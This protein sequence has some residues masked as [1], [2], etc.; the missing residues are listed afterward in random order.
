MNVISNELEDLSLQIQNYESMLK[1]KD[2][3]LNSLSKISIKSM[4]DASVSLE[5]KDVRQLKEL[6]K[7]IDLLLISRKTRTRASQS[8]KIYH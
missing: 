1:I 7:G 5:D 6:N 3:Q 2:Q 4:S 8:S